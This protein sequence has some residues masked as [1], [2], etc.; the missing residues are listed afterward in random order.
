M[1]WG[2]HGVQLTLRLWG[3]RTGENEEGKAMTMQAHHGP[4]DRGTEAPV[5]E[6]GVPA[7]DPS[8]DTSH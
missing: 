3:V 2:H 7:G 6:V 1:L 8:P 4:R 5:T